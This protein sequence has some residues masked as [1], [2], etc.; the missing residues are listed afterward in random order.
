MRSV[1]ERE[2]PRYARNEAPVLSLSKERICFSMR[3]GLSERLRSE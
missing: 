3:S 2:I 1:I